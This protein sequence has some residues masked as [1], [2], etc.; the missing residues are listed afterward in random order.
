MVLEPRKI[1]VGLIILISL[2]SFGDSGDKDVDPSC[3]SQSPDCVCN[4][5]EA[6][7]KL[8]FYPD[9]YSGDVLEQKIKNYECQKLERLP[10]SL[11]IDT[12]GNGHIFNSHDLST[13]ERWKNRKFLS[14]RRYIRR[15]K[16]YASLGVPT[17]KAFEE[18]IAQLDPEALHQ[19]VILGSSVTF[20]CDSVD[21]DWENPGKVNT[22]AWKHYNGDPVTSAQVIQNYWED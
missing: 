19:Y 8:K 11:V 20:E 21:E 5:P 22:V 13:D 9:V 3:V 4:I 14:Q 17:N 6:I 7:E 10:T 12:T 18:A 2:T 1:G 16:R 15:R